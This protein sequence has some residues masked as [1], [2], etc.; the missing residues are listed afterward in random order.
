MTGTQIPEEDR[1][2]ADLY[3]FMGLIL[4]GPPD[5]MLLDQCAGLNGDDTELG[6]GIATLAKLAR[7]TKPATVEAEFN[8]LFIGLGRGELLPY[9][10]YY[11]TGFLNEKPLALLRQDMAARG[12]A[13]A[14]TVFEPEDNIASLMEMMGAMIAGRFG[15]P[16]TLDQ[17]KT[18]F[19]KHIA[20]WAGHFF[21]DL[22]GAKTSVFYAPVGK[23]GRAFMEVESEAFRLS[24]T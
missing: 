15:T 9:A 16:A 2:R 1:L 20:P 11:L 6:Q 5:R 24:G 12:L 7:L 17:Q 18:F 22:E 14:D 4:S 8:R 10:S 21:S 13:R 3:N 23:I 19:G